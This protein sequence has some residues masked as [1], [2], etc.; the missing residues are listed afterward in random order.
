MKSK[1]LLC[2]AVLAICNLSC[3]SNIETV[4]ADFKKE[5]TE[6]SNAPLEL[7]GTRSKATG[8]LDKDGLT[9]ILELVADIS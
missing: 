6:L 8:A 4:G 5:L 9:A 1:L 2:F 7:F 3:K